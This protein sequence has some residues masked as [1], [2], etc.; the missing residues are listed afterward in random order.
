MRPLKL[1]VSA[2]AAYKNE[3]TIDFESLGDRGL[4]LITGDTGAGKTTL[5][6][7][8]IYALYGEAS[9]DTRKNDMLRSKYADPSVPTFAELEFECRGVRYT[10]RRSPEY[11]RPKARG[12]GFTTSPAAAELRKGSEVLSVKSS[13]MTK[14]IEEIIGVNRSQF[15]QIAMIAQGDFL[16]LLLAKTDDRIAVFRK[17]FNTENY[18]RLQETVKADYTELKRKHD[19]LRSRI[20]EFASA[21]YVEGYA[22]DS[23]LIAAVDKN[24]G[25]GELHLAKLN[26]REKEFSHEQ[27]KLTALIAKAEETAKNREAL[28]KNRIAMEEAVVKKAAAVNKLKAAEEK[29]PLC[30]EY[31]KRSAEISAVLSDYDE[32]T[33]KLAEKSGTEKQ[34]H[35]LE[36][37]LNTDKAE[38]DNI[39]A[40]LE[41]NRSEL[42]LLKDCGAEAEKIRAAV[43]KC[44]AEAIQL[45]QLMQK[46][47]SFKDTEKEYEKAAADYIEASRRYEEVNRLYREKETAFLNGQAGVLASKLKDGMPCMVCGSCVHPSP[48]VFSEDAPTQTELEKFKKDNDRLAEERNRKSSCA[49]EV[50]GQLDSRHSELDELCMKLLGNAFNDEAK[51]AA[52]SLLEEKNT[53]LE[54]GKAS[55]EKIS[56]DIERAAKLEKMT[57]E[58]STKAESLAEKINENERQLAEK[59]SALK[60]TE[61][62]ISK[63]SSQLEFTDKLQAVLA[64]DELEKKIS[65][66]EAAIEA[67]RTEAEKAENALSALEGEKSGLEKLLEGAEETDIEQLKIK[68]SELEKQKKSLDEEKSTVN[69]RITMNRT[70]LENIRKLSAESEKTMQE[71]IWL[72]ALNDAANGRSGENGKVMLETHVQTMYFDRIL[73]KAN[74][75]FKEMTG[76]QYTLVR[77]KEADDHRSQ[78]G[79]ELDVMDHC[80]GTERSVRT[81]SGG[82]SFKASLA[83]ALGLAD[84]VQESAGGVRLD[85]MFIDEGFG[86]LDAE[87]LNQALRALSDL[88]GSNRLVGIISH[89][90][91]LKGRIERQIRIT[92]DRSGC[93]KAEIIN[94]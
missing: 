70:A 13:D 92:K 28:K 81:L 44:E 40:S 11:M 29:R 14:K 84:V 52:E 79:L 46:M 83:L 68:K 23:E 18:N 59:R 69:V 49:G 66:T 31:R 47:A 33:A 78:T 17:L 20:G 19:G 61:E 4:Y 90:A 50:K 51:T 12:E 60:H 74:I 2:F 5:F 16:K 67:A 87:S 71:L 58:H 62:Y 42:A 75:R 37:S 93:S 80:N 27:E 76:G 55:L 88:S 41:K 22:D 91:E 53:A 85:S 32:L 35:L 38:S 24:I 56:K 77:R 94:I 7:G 73:H 21:V 25:I 39:K 54:N 48:A 63:L 72:G 45:K 65:E 8:I 86:S 57:E 82:E 34:L 43:D 26:D 30:E 9:G 6:D 1:T 3:T 15:S 64:I 10:A 36:T 89:V